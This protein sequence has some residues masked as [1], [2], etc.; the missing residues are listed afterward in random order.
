M[1]DIISGL[2]LIVVIGA[3][4]YYVHTI[5]QMLFSPKPK[6]VEGKVEKEIDWNARFE[7]M[8]S[9]RHYLW[10]EPVVA[11]QTQKEWKAEIRREQKQI[12]H[13]IEMEKMRMAKAN[14]IARLRPTSPSPNFFFQTLKI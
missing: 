5:A 8:D 3:V 1:L 14:W 11:P 9:S 2:V 10:E 6:Q 7:L 12:S 4:A 13:K